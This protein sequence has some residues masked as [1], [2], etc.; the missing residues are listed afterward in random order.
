MYCVY[1][2]ITKSAKKEIRA[3]ERKRIF[4][5]RRLR[6]MRSL[7]KGVLEKNRSGDSAGAREMYKNAQQAIDKAAKRGIIKPRN[8]SRKKL[9]LARAIKKDS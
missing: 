3:S 6:V 5:L 9:V 7:M 4:N 1:M 2:A 8:A